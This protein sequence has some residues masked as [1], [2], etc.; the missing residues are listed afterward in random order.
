MAETGR[1]D[2]ARPALPSVDEP[3]AVVAA[4]HA[5]GHRPPRRSAC[6]PAR[7][8]STRSPSL[9]E[10]PWRIADRHARVRPRRGRARR[11][12]RAST[13]SWPA[14]RA[15]ARAWRCGRSR[16]RWPAR[17]GSSPSR[18]RRSPLRDCPALERVVADRREPRRCRRTGRPAGPARRRRRGRR[19]AIDG[20][21]KRPGPARHRGRPLRRAALAVRPLD[22]DRPALEDRGAAA[23]EHRPRRRPARRHAAAPLAGADGRRPRLPGAQRRVGHRPGRAP[24][25]ATSSH[26]QAA[27]TRASIYTTRGCVCLRSEG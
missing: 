25:P 24:G 23:A 18:G 6:C 20:L 26:D 12:T 27:A 1:A 3:A 14:R 10:E 8:R 5:G 11:S 17:R 9:D 21:L 19:R 15:A 7:S 2:P 16:R 22:A 4:R 13:R